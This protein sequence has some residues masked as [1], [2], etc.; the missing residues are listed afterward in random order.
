MIMKKVY[1]VKDR[2]IENVKYQ[3][4]SGVIRLSSNNSNNNVIN[5]Y[6]NRIVGLYNLVKSIK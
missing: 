5:N 3:I 1:G 4:L 6:S 2:K